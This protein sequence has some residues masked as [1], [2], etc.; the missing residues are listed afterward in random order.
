[1]IVLIPLL[2]AVPAVA[3]G[4]ICI[5]D[6]CKQVVPESPESLIAPSEPEEEPAPASEEE[7][8][9]AENPDAQ[10]AAAEPTEPAVTEPAPVVAD[11]GT[12]P[13]SI[14]WP[15]IH[16]YFYWIPDNAWPYIEV[17][18]G[19][20]LTG[21]LTMQAFLATGPSWAVKIGRRLAWLGFL[22]FMFL[23]SRIHSNKVLEQPVRRKLMNA[24]EADAA[25]DVDDLRQAAGV[26]W[27]TA[28][29]HLRH[30]ESHGLVR[31]I[32]S[33]KKRLYFAAG[34]DESRHRRDMAALGGNARRRVARAVLDVPGTT[35]A[36]IAQDLGIKPPSV[37]HHLHALIDA[38]FVVAE[39]VGR[40]QCLTPTERLRT[41]MRPADAGQ[42][43]LPTHLHRQA[44][45][46]RSTMS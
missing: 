6:H 27:S 16:E 43:V 38:G 30:L 13:A 45:M 5:N 25:L 4:T 23:F 40:Q 37:S 36:E 24:I 3:Q 29:H 39:K 33:G 22:P 34:T 1:M 9:A 15:S 20:I 7:H 17:G 26:S 21:V 18:I 14:R 42:V 2:F 19:A 12:E 35:N 32:R 41:V 11:E 10:P 28:R 46:A 44:T 8:V 31:S